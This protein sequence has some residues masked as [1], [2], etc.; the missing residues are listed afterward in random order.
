MRFNA[1]KRN[2]T[3]LRASQSLSETFPCAAHKALYIKEKLSEGITLRALGLERSKC[4]AYPSQ[5]SGKGWGQRRWRGD[6]QLLLK[7]DVQ[8]V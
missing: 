5:A 8:Y 3:P 7:P 4:T 6:G 1:R 2:E